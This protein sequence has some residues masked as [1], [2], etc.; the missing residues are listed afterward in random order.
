[1]TS[2][3]V[4]QKLIDK[5][6]TIAFAESMTGG[7]LAYELIKY[8]NASK[9]VLASIVS[10]TPQMKVDLLQVNPQ[11]I[12][13]HQ[14]VS[15]E[16]AHEMVLSI[17]DKTNADVC[18]SIT[19]NAGPS[20]AEHTT[21]KCCYYAILVHKNIR[22]FKLIL[23]KNTREENISFAIEDVFESLEQMI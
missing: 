22:H 2:K 5:G 14:V 8:P 3:T 18:L 11:T 17:K 7:A 21:E 23:N 10:Y 15:K 20:L 6:L 4:F 12:E 9:T 19:G 16:V 1:M 13:K